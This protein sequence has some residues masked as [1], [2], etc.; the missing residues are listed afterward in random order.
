MKTAVERIGGKC[1]VTFTQGNQTFSIEGGG[2]KK[3]AEWT[4]R[5]LNIA[6]KN[7]DKEI[8]EM[9]EPI[10]KLT[11]ELIECDIPKENCDRCENFT[12]IF[13]ALTELKN[14]IK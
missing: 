5:Q 10:I 6:F 11:K 8:V 13:E 7:Y 12:K 9:I 3:E 14:K 4:Q 1:V 2:T